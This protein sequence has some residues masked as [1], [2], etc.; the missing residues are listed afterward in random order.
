MSL[1]PAGPLVS[2]EWLL[3]H[4]GQA[5]VLDASI[6][7]RADGYFPGHEMFAAGHIPGSRSLPYASLLGADHRLDLGRTTQAA[8]DLGLPP[9]GET[10][11]YCGGGINAAGLALAFTAIGLEGLR[12][13]DGSLSEWRADP[14]RP[15]RTGLLP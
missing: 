9:R 11:F 6:D 5:L 14:S 4:H 8:R 12:L 3:A 15:L 2:A 13:Y 1:L 10:V 7:R